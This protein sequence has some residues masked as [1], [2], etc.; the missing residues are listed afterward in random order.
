LNE[1]TWSD[2][3]PDVT[4]SFATAS[5]NDPVGASQ[6]FYRVLVTQ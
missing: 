6:R 3:V 4:A 5:I 1:L 2:L